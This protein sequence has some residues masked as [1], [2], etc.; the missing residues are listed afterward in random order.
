[1]RPRLR[2]KETEGGRGRGVMVEFLLYWSFSFSRQTKKRK[3]NRRRKRRKNGDIFGADAVVFS[4]AR[5]GLLRGWTK[6][7]IMHA[8]RKI[9]FD[10]EKLQ[11]YQEAIAFVA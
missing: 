5:H 9:H 11:V 10:H 2:I 6:R 4:A 8:H 3:R 7:W 1:M